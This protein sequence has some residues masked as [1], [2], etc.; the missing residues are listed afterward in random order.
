M[1]DKLKIE[2]AITTSE[3]IEDLTENMVYKIKIIKKYQDTKVISNEVSILGSQYY[4]TNIVRPVIE[5]EEITDTSFRI[6]IK[7]IDTDE[8]LNLENILYD[9]YVNEELKIENTT[10]RSEI[11]NGLGNAEKIKVVKKYKELEFNSNILFAK[12]ESNENYEFQI[13]DYPIM[14]TNGM[15]NVKY[16]NLAD[17][18]DYFYILNLNKDCTATDA[19]D[20]AAYDG[21][22]STYFD[23]TSGKCKFYF[24]DDIDIYQVCFKIDSSYSGN[25][26]VALSMNG[27]IATHEGKRLTNGAFHTTYY[28]KNST[29]WRNA[30][31]KLN[32]Q[33][34][35]IYYDG[36]IE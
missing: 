12:A 14:T 31:T 17:E 3:I 21:D 26:F 2:N 8:N 10:S 25:V 36:Y 23:P 33:T 16:T 19:L 24:G 1:N 34:Y 32:P 18:N 6:T 5:M 15:V 22:E 7:N 28:G 13:L 27:Y 29:A 35:E 9:Y 4:V 20:K 11:L 30:F